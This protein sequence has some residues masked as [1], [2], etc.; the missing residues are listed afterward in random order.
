[1]SF[2]SKQAYR[3]QPDS[4]V[5][6]T[7]SRIGGRICQSISQKQTLDWS[8][9]HR[10]CDTVLVAFAGCGLHKTAISFLV[11]SLSQRAYEAITPIVDFCYFFAISPY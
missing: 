4:A 2:N 11:K 1:M 9:D 6:E 5:R 10:R 7:I 3:S 8:A